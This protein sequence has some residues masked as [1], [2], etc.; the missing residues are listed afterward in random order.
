MNV[1]RSAT[2]VRRGRALSNLS[3]TQGQCF[4]SPSQGLVQSCC[5]RPLARCDAPSPGDGSNERGAPRARPQ[6]EPRKIRAARSP[7]STPG[8]RAGLVQRLGVLLDKQRPHPSQPLGDC[9]MDSWG[10]FRGVA[11]RCTAAGATGDDPL[12]P[13]RLRLAAEGYRGAAMRDVPARD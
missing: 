11:G 2:S 10:P 7:L 9:L 13:H 1:Q 6:N 5:C 3:I 8:V 4:A 12:S